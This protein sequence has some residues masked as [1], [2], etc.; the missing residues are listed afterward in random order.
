MFDFFRT[1]IMALLYS[2]AENRLFWEGKFGYRREWLKKPWAYG[3][4]RFKVYHVWMAFFFAVATYTPNYAQWLMHNL[5]AP[6]IVDFMWFVWEGRER[7]REDWSNIGDF[8][9]LYGMFVWYYIDFALCIILA[10]AT[11]LW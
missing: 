10:V 7:K 3:I 11:T 1:V 9:L 6:L 4:G 2:V 5:L 8:P